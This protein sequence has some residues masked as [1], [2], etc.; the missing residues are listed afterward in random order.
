MKTQISESCFKG[1]RTSKQCRARFMNHLDPYLRHEPWTFA[2]NAALKASAEKKNR[3]MSHVQTGVSLCTPPPPSLSI[4]A[5]F[6]QLHQGMV[7][8]KI[9]QRTETNIITTLT[10]VAE[11][12]TGDICIASPGEMS[13]LSP[14]LPS[15]EQFIT[16]MWLSVRVCVCMYVCMVI[17]YSR[18]WINRVRLPILLVVS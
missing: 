1:K 17:T 9:T 16:R 11:N 10:P 5:F 13:Y 2:E 15:L 3:N 4:H 6:L 14:V 18:V 7:V 12:L 8:W